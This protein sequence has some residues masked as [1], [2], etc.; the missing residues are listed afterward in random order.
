MKGLSPHYG[1]AGRGGTAQ[2]CL[3]L[4]AASR[5]VPPAGGGGAL[6]GPMAPHSL[7]GCH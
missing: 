5:L 4:G 3:P 2:P 6:E 7:G 1:R